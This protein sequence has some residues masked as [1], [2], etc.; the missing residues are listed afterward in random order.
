MKSDA[1]PTHVVAD[2]T[3]SGSVDIHVPTDVVPYEKVGA[4]SPV[5]FTWSL[6]LTTS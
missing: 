1:L 5:R 6:F 3:K 2:E 4:F